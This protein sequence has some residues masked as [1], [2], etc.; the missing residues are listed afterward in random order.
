M[1]QSMVVVISISILITMLVILPFSQPNLVGGETNLSGI[2]NSDT[3]WA[4]TNSPINFSGNVLVPAGVTL[5]I[6]PGV[7]VN[8]NSFYL[9]VNGTLRSMGN[10]ANK[11]LFNGG[12]VL[13][14]AI[15]FN[16][17]SNW[18]EATSSGN[19]IDNTV[20]F[21]GSVAINSGSPKISNSNVSGISVF[22]STPVISSNTVRIGV[23]VN[24]GP[25]IVQGNTVEGEVVIEGGSASVTHNN[26]TGSKTR[27]QG[28]LVQNAQ[29]QISNNI[30]H[31]G[32]NLVRFSAAEISNN[33]IGGDVS[34]SGGVLQIFNNTITGGTNGIS[35]N[36]DSVYDSSADIHDNFISGYSQAGIY[37]SGGYTMGI[38]GP[39]HDA[40]VIQRNLITDNLYGIQLMGAEFTIQNNTITNNNIGINSQSSPSYDV[41]FNN[42]A[43]NS[44]NIHAGRDNFNAT[45]NWWGTTDQQ[46]INQSIYDFKNDFTLGVVTFIPYLTT[47]NPE[48][49]PALNAAAP[50]ASPMP[51]QTQTPNQTPSPS[52]PE[53]PGW[54][55]LPLA[56]AATLIVFMKKKQ[57]PAHMTHI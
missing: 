20:L 40:L 12:D 18:N 7:I 22:G 39:T 46:A 6:Q 34:S 9:M 31:G 24:S 19:I 14:G 44:Q 42:I 41:T 48:A 35:I 13:Y 26:I 54:I 15:I 21:T 29:A 16:S 3:I 56:I 49:V 57:R 25:T 50:T 27:N 36:Q 55:L 33:I 52:V 1:K 10:A 37:G 30:V 8:L 23:Y 53:F 45:H 11:I 28:I 2:L 43:N 17:L 32:I 5:T 4:S 47:P 38:F 51:T